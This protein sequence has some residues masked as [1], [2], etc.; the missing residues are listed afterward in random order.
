MIASAENKQHYLTEL[1]HATDDLIA[2]RDRLRILANEMQHDEPAAAAFVR[3]S[4]SEVLDVLDSIATTEGL[5][6]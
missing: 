5:L 4:A 1:A 3:L 2:A 6:A